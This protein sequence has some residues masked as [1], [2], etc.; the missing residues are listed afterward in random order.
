MVPN[1]AI[2]G[3]ESKNRGPGTW[4]RVFHAVE[5]AVLENSKIVQRHK[6]RS[7]SISNDA[8]RRA[9]QEHVQICQK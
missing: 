4:A 6:N 2:E 1:N 5:N 7:T 3:G 8:A 9:E